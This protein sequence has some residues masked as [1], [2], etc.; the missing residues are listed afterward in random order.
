[1]GD[2][3]F[4]NSRKRAEMFADVEARDRA[5][6]RACAILK[7]HRKISEM[8]SNSSNSKVMP[9]SI[10]TGVD[11]RFGSKVPCDRGEGQ[12]KK[13]PTSEHREDMRN[14]TRSCRHDGCKHVWAGRW[15][16]FI[17]GA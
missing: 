16:S 4:L 11:P 5:R 3:D 7:N 13:I 9:E 2:Q 10:T 14:H 12:F 17:G 8:L 1:M 15:G 6:N